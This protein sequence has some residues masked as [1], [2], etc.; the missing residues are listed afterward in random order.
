MWDAIG[1]FF[2][3][4]AVW[5]DTVERGGNAVNRVARVAERKAK[6]FE[7]QTKLEDKAKLSKLKAQLAEA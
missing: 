3:A 2:S 5:F 6:T 4:L 1:K 7:I